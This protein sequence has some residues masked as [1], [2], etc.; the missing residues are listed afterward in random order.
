M[1]SVAKP[2]V[3]PYLIIGVPFLISFKANLCPKGM[4]SKRVITALELE[5]A[6]NDSPVVKGIRPVATLSLVSMTMNLSGTTDLNT[7]VVRASL[8]RVI[9]AGLDQ[10]FVW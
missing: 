7:Y 6:D 2:I 4:S 1:S 10:R 9:V 8:P 3:S 5:L